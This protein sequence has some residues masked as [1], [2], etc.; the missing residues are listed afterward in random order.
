MYATECA[1]RGICIDWRGK[2]NFTCPY[3]KCPANTVYK[4]CGPINPATCEPSYVEH[5]GYGVTEGCFCPEG[6]TL[7]SED[8]SICVSECSCREPNGISRTPGEKWMKDCQECV[9]DK[10]TLKVHCT[11]HEC[12]L[13]QP[14][15]CHDPGYVPVQVQ[16]PE[17]PCCSRT[18]C[19]CNTSLCPEV[20]HKCSAGQEIVTTT[21]PGKC[22]PSF[23]C[24][25]GC[26]V[27]GTFYPVST[28]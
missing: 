13:T 1:A 22:C 7:I 21:Q 16:V 26:G 2:T 24:E 20:T 15:Y 18:E 6:Q 3:N 10:H 5:S 8:S 12:P 11:R 28:Q 23:E 17:D 19:F 9:C 14:V 4:A 25:P 27:N